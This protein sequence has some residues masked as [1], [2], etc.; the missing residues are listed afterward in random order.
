MDQLEPVLYSISTSVG[1]I[2]GGFV[3]DRSIVVVVTDPT[4]RPVGTATTVL[5][6]AVEEGEDVPAAVIVDT[7]K[8]YDTPED[9]P[10][11][12]AAAAAPRLLWFH[13]VHDPPMG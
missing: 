11:T 10:V 9:R 13:V 5:A 1:V 3:Q 12:V 7:R 8:E 6:E 2:D 4:I